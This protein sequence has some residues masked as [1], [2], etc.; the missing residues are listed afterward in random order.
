VSDL[1]ENQGRWKAELVQNMFLPVDAD[2][3]LKIKPSRRLD[4]DILAWQPENSGVFFGS[5]R[6]SV[7]VGTNSG[8]MWLS[9]HEW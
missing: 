3:I 4:G 6:L 2:I 9:S 7:S 1:L 8:A 5:E